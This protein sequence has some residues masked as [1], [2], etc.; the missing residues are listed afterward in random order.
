MSGQNGNNRIEKYLDEEKR[1]NE[2]KIELL[3]D[4]DSDGRLSFHPVPWIYYQFLSIEETTILSALINLAIQSASL[5]KTKIGLHIREMEGEDGI[6]FWCSVRRLCNKFRISSRTEKRIIKSLADKGYIS[7]KT[8][9]L[10]RR[11]Y[12]RIN[13]ENVKQSVRMARRNS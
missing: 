4:V 6:W 2:M 12:F 13:M 8:I 11:R 9:S 3:S 1:H 10:K 5:K 7:K